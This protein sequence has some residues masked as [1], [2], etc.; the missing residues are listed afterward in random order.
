MMIS[1]SLFSENSVAFYDTGTGLVNTGSEIVIV[2][3]ILV[4]LVRATRP[5]LLSCILEW[6]RGFSVRYTTLIK[7]FHLSF[8]YL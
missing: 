7:G 4:R 8:I 2:C 3:H 5:E 1:E 6:Y